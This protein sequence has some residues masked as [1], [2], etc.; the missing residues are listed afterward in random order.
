MKNFI[1]LYDPGE[2]EKYRNMILEAEKR[3]SPSFNDYNLMHNNRND[4]L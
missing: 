1:E 4:F 2:I 3:L